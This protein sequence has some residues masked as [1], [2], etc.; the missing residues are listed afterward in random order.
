MADI[1]VALVG[2]ISGFS[3][4]LLG[5]FTTKPWHMY[6]GIVLGLFAGIVL[7]TIRSLISKSSPIDAI[8]KY[9]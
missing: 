9:K 6:V 5:S 4:T 2:C 1:K 7:P 3:A 8:G